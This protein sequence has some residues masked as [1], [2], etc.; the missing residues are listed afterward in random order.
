MNGLSLDCVARLHYPRERDREP[1]GR[2]LLYRD[3]L[4]RGIGE[5]H[6]DRRCARGGNREIIVRSRRN[7]YRRE[8]EIAAK[9]AARLLRGTELRNR[10]LENDR[11]RPGRCGKQQQ[12]EEAEEE[13]FHG[14]FL[15][16]Q[17]S[18]VILSGVVRS[19][20]ESCSAQDDNMEDA[21]PMRGKSPYI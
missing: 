11:L 15:E 1:A 5:L 13:C 8:P 14:L 21:P 10:V 6:E 16:Y 20:A 4:Q 2:P 9:R 17:K 18:D 12:G 7:L 3:R 19:E